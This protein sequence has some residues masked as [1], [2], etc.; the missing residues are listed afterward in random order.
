MAFRPVGDLRLAL[1]GED[2]ARFAKA[3]GGGM[4]LERTDHDG[5]VAVFGDGRIT[6]T[7]QEGLWPGAGADAQLFERRKPYR[8]FGQSAARP[9][10]E[11][12][13]LATVADQALLGLRAPLITFVDLRELLRLDLDAGYVGERAR[14]LGLARALHGATLLVAHYFPEVGSAA[15]RLRPPL[16]AAERLAVEGVVEAGRDPSRLRQLRGLDAAAR[17]VVAPREPGS[18]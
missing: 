11:E 4:T 5:R 14:A 1:R 13:V 3:I 12:A 15:E 18:V 9:S 8:A 6:L 2:G 7:V 17:K 10:A 16:G